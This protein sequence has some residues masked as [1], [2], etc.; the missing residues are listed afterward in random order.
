MLLTSLCTATLAL[1]SVA[2]HNVSALKEMPT[3][4]AVSSAKSTES[5]YLV[6]VGKA[7]I[8]GPAAETGMFGYAAKQMV[9][10]LNDRLYSRAFII[11]EV[12]N[13]ESKRVVYVSTD[14]GAMFTSV[15]LEVIKRLHTEYGALYREDNVML[16][17]THTHVGNGGFS[18]Q[19]LYQIASQDDTL[20]GYSQQTFE[21]IVDGIVRSIKQA[22]NSLTPGK[23]SLA[24][25]KLVQATRNRSLPAYYANPDAKDSDSTVNEVMTQLR[26][27]KADDSPLGLINWFAIH[28]TSFSNKFTHLSADNKG[29]AQ[30][31]IEAKVKQE[32]NSNFVAAF[33]NTDEGDVVASGGNAYS[34]PGFEGSRNEWQN[35][36]RDGS[37]QLNK[38]IDLWDKGQPVTGSI[39]TRAR[40]VDLQGYEVEAQYTQGA[41]PQKLCA[42]AR[43]YSFAAG[44][45]NGPSN[46]TGI[47]E[48]MTRDSLRLTDS[49]NKVDTSVLG[50]ATRSAFGIVSTGNQDKCQAEKPVLLPTGS[51]G[52]VNNEQPVQLM[53]IG[54]LALIAIPGEPTTMV[55]RHLRQAVSNQLAPTGVNTLVIAGLANNYSG[56]IT[57]RA[58]Y[59]KQHYEGAS[60]EFGPYQ[61]NAYLQ[62]YVQLAQAMREGKP[63]R[64]EIAP[65]DRSHKSFAERPGVS[66]DD[67][68]V[69]QQWGEVL[70]Q[71]NPSYSKGNTVSVVFRGAHP[72]NNLRTEDSFLIVQQ[73]NHG[74][75]IDYKKDSDFDTTYSWQREKLAYSKITIDWRIGQDTAPGTYRIVHQGD[76]KNGWDGSITPYTGESNSFQVR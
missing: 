76:W 21:A 38:A 74:S 56:Y 16:T 12:D 23:L 26:L 51:W 7:D 22:H 20:A 11:A 6:G 41:G 54:N 40:W 42:P 49:L 29:Y 19:K 30:L 2:C 33:A 35:V 52:W 9:T 67:K 61:A 63:I 72:K 4:Q 64:N 47:Y 59:A 15:K 25:G 50:T 71:P 45:E 28:P 5:N 43:G 70:Q 55:G 14:L 1:N 73:L 10:G 13:P 27:N 39:D 32:N 75:W 62:Q 34:A 46:I 8:T 44:A 18:H 69:N 60:T 17:A 36:I 68:P 57:T 66:F 53:R 3:S 58:E 37:L 65:P 24:Q 48:G 31:G